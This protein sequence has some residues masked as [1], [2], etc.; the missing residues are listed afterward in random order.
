VK[1]MTSLRWSLHA[2]SFT[3]YMGSGFTQR[4]RGKDVVERKYATF[5]C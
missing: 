3:R 2:A 5:D 4:M 1:K